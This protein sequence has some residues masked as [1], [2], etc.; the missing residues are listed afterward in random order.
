MST[1]TVYGSKRYTYS[2]D[3][4]IDSPRHMI[5]YDTTGEYVIKLCS[6][7]SEEAKINRLVRFKENFESRNPE[8]MYL[9]HAFPIE[10][11]YLTERK[12]NW[13]GFVMRR[14]RDRTLEEVGIRTR[15]FK[16]HFGSDSYIE[17]LGVCASLCNCFQLLH[18][19]RFLL[20][21]VKPD[22]FL[23]TEKG[24]VYPIDTD[25]FSC[26]GS[27][28]QP[29]LPCYWPEGEVY[30]MP[31]RHTVEAESYALT[32]L[33]LQMLTGV[34][35][36]GKS[37]VADLRYYDL[38]GFGEYAHAMETNDISALKGVKL[39]FY[40]RWF[41]TPRP[42]REVFL[43]VIYNRRCRLLT[44]SG[45]YNLIVSCVNDLRVRGADTEIVPNW[46]PLAEPIG[47]PAY[48]LNNVAGTPYIWFLPDSVR[49]EEKKREQDEL[50]HLTQLAMLE[51][52]M[53]ELDKELG[54]ALRKGEEEEIK[55]NLLQLEL[56]Q[57]KGNEKESKRKINALRQERD[58]LKRALV[59]FVATTIIGAVFIAYQLLIGLT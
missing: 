44:A 6:D 50:R 34:S 49:N 27:T 28:S 5:F 52:K 59:I 24:E 9:V 30:S 56:T 15:G 16:D 14:C 42:I 8:F 17:F 55:A 54:A 39:L 51:G 33:L 37:R 3:D 43:D 23:V 12:N 40:K 11:I 32:V 20:S 25:G 21:D 29:P 36:A 38:A 53:L 41:L 4:K 18:R 35:L 7:K 13:I 47:N 46:L 2:T 26:A 31:Y 19:Q 48:Y 57:K 22:N 58:T 1:E 45:W 10:S